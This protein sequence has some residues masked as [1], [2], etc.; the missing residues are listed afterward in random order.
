[1]HWLMAGCGFTKAL[2][3]EMLMMLAEEVQVRTQWLLFLGRK[4]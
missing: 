3:Q 2:G 4:E 1:M